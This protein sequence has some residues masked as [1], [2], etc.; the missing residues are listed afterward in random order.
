LDTCVKREI[1]HK[2][3]FG[4]CYFHAIIQERKKFGPLGWNIK[5]EFNDSDLDTSKTVVKMLLSEGE[6][7]PWDAMLFVT[8]HINYGGRVT[9][10]WDRRCLITILKKF[11]SLEVLEDHYRFS[12]NHTYIIP[13]ISSVEDYINYIDKLPLTDDP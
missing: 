7:V 4:L 9:D 11:I 13:P 5:Y 8:G 6:T 1:F 10:D 3:T 12:E 2:L